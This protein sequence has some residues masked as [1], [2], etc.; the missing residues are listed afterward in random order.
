MPDQEQ[1]ANERFGPRV[2]TI[3]GH[4]KHMAYLG[5]SVVEIGP[6]HAVMKLPYRPELVGDPSRGVVFGGVI[7]TLIDQ[8]SGLAV[9][10]SL[11]ELMPMATIDLRIDY[12]RAADPGCD[13][14]ARS[15]C[16]KVTRNVAF[17][18]AIAWEKDPT[19]PFASG[20]GTFI[21]G[22]STGGSPLAG[23]VRDTAT[24]EGT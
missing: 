2:A 18:R 10:V 21:L 23:G 20:Q 5:I 19:N 9:A 14:Y 13:L 6:R 12:L 16:Y 7:T 8:A 24:P 4:T 3:M 1:A 11:E 22:T 15:D 17:V